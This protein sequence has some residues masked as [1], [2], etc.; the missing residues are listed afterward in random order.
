MRAIVL[1]FAVAALAALAAYI[2]RANSKVIS[3]ILLFVSLVCLCV[4]GVSIVIEQY[5]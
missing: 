4:L 3:N 5:E 2:I 1:Y